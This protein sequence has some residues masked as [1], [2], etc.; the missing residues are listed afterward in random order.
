MKAIYFASILIL[1]F[2]CADRKSS[3]DKKE[4]KVTEHEIVIA[5][6]QSI[7]DSANV[8][9]S[10]LIYDPG[11]DKFYSNDF[12][13]AKSGKLPASTFKIPNSIIALETGTVENDSTL[14][15][16][17]G[18]KRRLRDWEQD[19][20]F[21]DAFHFSCVPCY[22]E[23]ARKTGVKNMTEYL[24]KL[25]YGD[26]KV[27]SANIDLFWLE[28][29]SRISQFQ[30]I[31]FLKRFYKSELPISERTE[32]IMKRMIVI[33]ENDNYRLS[34]KTGWSIRNGN[35]NGWFVGYLETRNKTYFFATNVEPEQ[36]FNMDLFPMIRKDLTFKALEH[37]GIIK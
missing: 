29:D 15:K 37:L 22:Q 27:D 3:S 18:K 9:G 24:N 28:G 16:W 34:G 8:D 30:Q 31:D 11:D 21:R 2:S 36:Q 4:N 20:I 12:I 6:F 25:A 32:T 10:I 26:M 35:N 17:N 14:F 1:F 5:E 13:W 23:I 19:L 33:E 7:I